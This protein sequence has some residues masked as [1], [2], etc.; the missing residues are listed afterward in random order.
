MAFFSDFSP[1]S[2]SSFLPISLSNSARL[3]SKI[4]HYVI[5]PEM[6]SEGGGS[7]EADISLIMGLMV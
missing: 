7:V 2:L 3:A 6:L 5:F 1:F 4:S